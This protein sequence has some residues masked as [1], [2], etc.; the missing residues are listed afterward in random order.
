MRKR[1]RSAVLKTRAQIRTRCGFA[2]LTA[3][4]AALTSWSMVAPTRAAGEAELWKQRPHVMDVL[5]GK[6]EVDDLFKQYFE[7]YFFQQ[8]TQP[9]GR[10]YSLDDLPKLRRDLR[11]Y[12]SACRSP[13]AYEYL[14]AATLKRMKE[15][16][17]GKFDKAHDAA[18]KYNA[19]LAVGEMNDQEEGGKGKPSAAASALLVQ[20]LK[21]ADGKAVKDYMK[22][23]A[24]VS[25]E[26]HALVP[27][28]IGDKTRTELTEALVKLLEQKEPPAGRE[29]AAH[30]YMR[31]SAGQIL[32]ILGSP[33]PGNSVAKAMEGAASDSTA[34]PTFRCEM[35]QYL[36][37]LK[38]QKPSDAEVQRLAQCV[39]RQAVDVCKQEI[40]AA[41]AA[42]NRP[43]SRRMILYALDSAMKGL[44][45]TDG[46]SGLQAAVANQQSETRKAIGAV[47]LKLKTLSSEL[48]KSDNIT[49]DALALE[50][51]GKIGEL[52]NSLGLR[53]QT[54]TR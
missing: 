34:P 32:A 42:N 52:E 49:D 44:Q 50:V 48:E 40:D 17:K 21:A 15:I 26:R 25:L 12:F 29:A 1:R 27:G 35:V 38:Y 9:T 16:L 5:V 2:I 18:I 37:Q 14:S 41:R 47:Y 33:G 24:L 39:T 10:A 8:F 53:G 19:L 4:A 7:E 3:V 30:Q 54:A 46:R 11:N 6:A 51:S 23:A 28:A 43:P 45:G 36:G 22:A 31:R 20:L 13:A